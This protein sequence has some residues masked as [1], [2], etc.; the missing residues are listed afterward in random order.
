[1]CA[2]IMC[3]FKTA[4]ITIMRVCVLYPVFLPAGDAQTS[5]GNRPA[6]GENN[7]GASR[8]GSLLLRGEEG[9]G[10]CSGPKRGPPPLSAAPA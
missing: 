6:G 5:G 4:Q 10:L 7:G 1:M 3:I 9:S 8:P 2:N